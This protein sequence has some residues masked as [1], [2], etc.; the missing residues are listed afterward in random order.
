[1]ENR[2]V[3]YSKF[4]FDS[5]F[6][7]NENARFLQNPINFSIGDISP[8]STQDEDFRN[9]ICNELKKTMLY[10]PIIGD[11][12]LRVAI[13]EFIN[14]RD[15]TDFTQANIAVTAGS[16]QALFSVINIISKLGGE[17]IA[18]NPL[19][20]G[21]RNVAKING[22][23]LNQI[24][25]SDDGKLSVEN[26]VNSINKKTVGIII[27]YPENPTSRI[28]D[29]SSIKNLASTVKEKY[30][31]VFLI[32]DEAYLNLCYDKKLES[33]VRLL[34]DFDNLVVA[35]TFSKA[36]GM[37]GWRVG[38]AVAHKNLIK[39]FNLPIRGSTSNTSR[40]SQ[41][42]ALYALKNHEKYNSLILRELKKRRDALDR[43]LKKIK[44]ISYEFPQATLYFWVKFPI[45]GMEITKDL[46]IQKE[47]L[48][49]PGIF[50]GSNGQNYVRISFG[51]ENLERIK[52][53]GNRIKTYL[54]GG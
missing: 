19:W 10:E 36:Y 21:Y 40:L 39:R 30:P 22:L 41:I 16:M 28:Y 35:N 44:S 47:A 4:R 18:S 26:I 6:N 7:I 51:I 45:D 14:E 12:N 15:G 52:E 9:Y 53:G 5:L 25:F 11:L 50:F 32:I 13:A 33:C 38:Y 49:C 23:N 46:C 29:F 8:G 48:V 27:N 43:I 54:E 2:V 24:D 17:L 42:A 34:N 31:E 20:V 3:I 1:M 37:T